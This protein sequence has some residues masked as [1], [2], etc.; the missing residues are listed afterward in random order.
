M[1]LTACAADPCDC[2]G[3]GELALLPL[4]DYTMEFQRRV[5]DELETLP[6]GA[7]T[8]QMIGDYIHLR[9]QIRAGRSE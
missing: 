8:W 9:D 4:V 5:A 1:S 6:E 2:A 3:G 7:A